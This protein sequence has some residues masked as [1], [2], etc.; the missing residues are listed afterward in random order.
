[1][2]DDLNIIRCE[3]ELCAFFQLHGMRNEVTGNPNCCGK[4]KQR[5]CRQQMMMPFN[6]ISFFLFVSNHFLTLEIVPLPRWLLFLLLL[7]A[8]A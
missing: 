7:T 1:M 2:T 3:W 4:A 8:A 6:P 5:R